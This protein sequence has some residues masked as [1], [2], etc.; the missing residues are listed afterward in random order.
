MSLG[1]VPSRSQQNLV[2]RGHPKGRRR[3]NSFRSSTHLRCDKQNLTERRQGVT[4]LPEAHGLVCLLSTQGHA[5]MGT[6][7]ARRRGVRGSDARTPPPGSSL[8]SALPLVLPPQATHATPRPSEGLPVRP[9]S[10]PGS[11]LGL[12]PEAGRRST[13]AAPS[14]GCP[15]EANVERQESGQTHAV[16][17][18]A[19]RDLERGPRGGR[20][21][22]DAGS[23][24]GWGGPRGRGGAGP[25]R[26]PGRGGE[27]GRGARDVGGQQGHRGPGRVRSGG[28]E[29]RAAG[30]A[31]RTGLRR[32]RAAPGA[33]ARRAEGRGPG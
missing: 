11:R 21:G 12:R 26:G 29:S 27:Q 23:L 6:L 32:A 18:R 16:R 5:S 2:L 14:G 33:E 8:S 17:P 7:W 25:R 13:P 10:T 15:D 28:A 19:A 4:M 1:K 22:P 3:P 9:R 20:G 24:Q 30:C 31:E